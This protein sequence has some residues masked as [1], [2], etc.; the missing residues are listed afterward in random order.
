MTVPS[1]GLDRLPPIDREMTS[2]NPAALRLGALAGFAGFVIQ[3]VAGQAHPGVTAP[4]QSAAVF[5]E[6]AAS[7]VWTAVH[8]GQFAGG[9]LVALMLVSIARSL[10]RHG[11]AGA[12]ALVG[13]VAAVVWGAVFAVQMAVDGFALKATIDAWLAAPPADQPAAFLV[14]DGVRAIEKGL[15]SMF[16]LMNGTAILTL[17]LAVSLTRAYPRFLGWFGVAAGLGYVAGGIA[18][19]FVGFGSE[20]TLILGTALV[21]GVV[22]L[23]GMV[24]AM[25]RRASG[26]GSV[27]TQVV[28][29][30]SAGSVL[31]TPASDLAI[32]V[33]GAG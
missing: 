15:S 12:F 21:P 23:F 33:P 14:A 3:F 5:R 29:A 32:P 26:S 22:F 1:Q 31:H 7:D 10:P 11:L 27:A 19:A 17:G 13:G 2:T 28:E 30:T 20:A 16:H 24:V 9:M 4:N 6:Y 18:T 8:L 25:W